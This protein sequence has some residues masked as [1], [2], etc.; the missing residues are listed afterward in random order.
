MVF[1]DGIIGISGM[2]GSKGLLHLPQQ[3]EQV[4]ELI[5]T[6]HGEETVQPQ[7]HL[8][9]LREIRLRADPGVSS[10]IRALKPATVRV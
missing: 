8:R 1:I 5:G 3:D 10:G 9:K 7:I 4:G 2:I 6:R